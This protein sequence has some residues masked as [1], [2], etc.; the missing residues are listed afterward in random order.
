VPLFATPGHPEYPSGHSCG[1]G[2]AAAV[3]AAEFGSNV[4]I[5]LDSDVMLGVQQRYRGPA[6]ALEQ[7]KNARIHAGIHFR[8]ACDVGTE[9][10][11]A[12]ANFVLQNRFQRLH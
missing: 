11:A 10:G 6:D 7:V 5:T 2:A 12:V 1:S 8:T 4:P 3:L 9:L